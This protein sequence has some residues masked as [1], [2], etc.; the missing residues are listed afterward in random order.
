[1]TKPAFYLKT[2]LTL[3]L[4]IITGLYCLKTYLYHR[5]YTDPP[6]NIADSVLIEKID[7]TSQK[8]YDEKVIIYSR[9]II[10]KDGIFEYYLEQDEHYGINVSDP[11]NTPGLKLLFKNKLTSEQLTTLKESIQTK[12]YTRRTETI[13]SKYIG[14]NQNAPKNHIG[15]HFLIKE[16]NK[17]IEIESSQ[18]IYDPIEP[19]INIIAEL[20][21]KAEKDLTDQQ[22]LYLNSIQNK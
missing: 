13:I 21:T 12:K 14:S 22:R 18:S 6:Y 5:V 4:V 20:V 8:I 1:M 10:Y 16:G 17:T 19:A 7:Q 11:Y 15:D 2:C 9:L 3:L